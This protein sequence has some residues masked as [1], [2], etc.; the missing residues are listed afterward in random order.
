MKIT[1]A[2]AHPRKPPDVEVV[3]DEN[4][5]DVRQWARDYVNLLLTLEGVAIVPAKLPRAS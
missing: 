2:N 1:G 4:V 3:S 5:V